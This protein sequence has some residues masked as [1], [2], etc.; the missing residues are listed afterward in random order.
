MTRDP[1]KRGLISTRRKALGPGDDLEAG[2]D[3]EGG[4]PP[5]WRD[6]GGLAFLKNDSVDAPNKDIYDNWYIYI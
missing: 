4:Q 2:T 3:T 5:R 6:D 1:P